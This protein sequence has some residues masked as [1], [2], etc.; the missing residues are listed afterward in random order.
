M[1]SSSNFCHERV[2]FC[3]NLPKLS[4]ALSW[5]PS[6]AQ[7]YGSGAQ[8]E[9]RLFSFI[10]HFYNSALERPFSSINGYHWLWCQESNLC[11]RKKY[12]HRTVFFILIVFEGQKWPL[13][14][15]LSRLALGILK[16]GIPLYLYIIFPLLKKYLNF[17][18]M[19]WNLC[20]RKMYFLK[21]GIWNKKRTQ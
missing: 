7:A 15:E 21:F 11:G 18:L 19:F 17:F 16:Y 3:W 20:Q 9:Y 5:A 6:S 10:C 4:S 1:F 2:W 14:M 13:F 12:P 8:S